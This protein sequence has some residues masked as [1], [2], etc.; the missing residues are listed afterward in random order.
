MASGIRRTEGRGCGKATFTPERFT[1][2]RREDKVQ[3][4]F[5]AG[6]LRLN[7]YPEDV[8]MV[9]E[10]PPRIPFRS[11]QWKHQG[12]RFGAVPINIFNRHWTGVIVDR[13]DGGGG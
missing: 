10:K 9:H 1:L 13:G 5:N 3:P 6:M 7:E 11:Q 8:S 4:I 12:T 2:P